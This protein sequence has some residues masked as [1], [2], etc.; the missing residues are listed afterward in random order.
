MELEAF[1]LGTLYFFG[2]LHRPWLDHAVLTWTHLGDLRTL[3][4][5]AVF[6][7]LL[8]GAFRRP[9]AGGAL[10]AAGLLAWALEWGVKRLVGRPRPQVA[11]QLLAPP[12]DP[13]FPSG[14]ALCS[15][16][17]Y[18]GLG[19]LLSRATRR[20]WLRALLGGA[21]IALGVSVGLTRPYLGVH[22]PLD[23]VAGWCAGLACALLAYEAGARREP[24]AP[25][26]LTPAQLAG[27]SGGAP[28]PAPT[29]ALRPADHGVSSPGP[30]TA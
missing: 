27:W 4:L 1:D 20:R 11:W 5:V 9:R 7:A 8:F 15:M 26:A 25:A 19:L 21:G 30:P 22:Y 23:V 29:D 28:R 6:A 14:H 12:D 3:A 10:V 13:S 17:V 18:G 16:A 24:P 2:S